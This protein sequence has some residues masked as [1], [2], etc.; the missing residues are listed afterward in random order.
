MKRYS[1][2]LLILFSLLITLG[3]YLLSKS[4]L[5][6][7]IILPWFTLDQLSAL[8]GSVLFA[9]SFILASRWAWIEL[10][11]G[12]LDQIYRLHQKI[13]KLAFGLLLAHPLFLLAA[14]APMR[15]GDAGLLL[16]GGNLAN[17]LGKAGLLVMAIIIIALIYG[18]LRYDWFVKI[19]KFFGLALAF[20]I[21]HILFVSSDVADYWPLG[22]W[23]ILLFACGLVAYIYR[24]LLYARLSRRHYYEVAEINNHDNPPSQRYGEASQIIEFNLRPLGKPLKHHGGQFAYFSFCSQGLTEEPHPFSLASGNEQVLRLACRLCGDWTN[25]LP[26]VKVGDKVTVFGPHG[27][28]YDDWQ[29]YRQT[30]AVAGGIGITPFLGLL[31]AER[32]KPRLFGGRAR[33]ANQTINFFYACKNQTEAIF[34]AELR[35]LTQTLNG[36]TYN[37]CLSQTDGRL[38]ADKLLADVDDLSSTAVFLCGPATM[39]KDLAKQLQARGM[40]KEQIIFEDFSYH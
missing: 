18:K 38:T 2:K 12:G 1:G 27:H 29:K 13:G 30:I 19:Q 32:Q 22:W 35:A 14:Y 34:D 15:G 8:L 11:F 24:E 3:F 21:F 25:L 37:L 6:T 33:T 10:A 39:M 36:L 17:D 40:K 16:P 9:W 23:M 28:F 7:V 5:S 31:D 26:Q 4:D 20:G